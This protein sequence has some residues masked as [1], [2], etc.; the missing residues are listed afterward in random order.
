LAEAR[1]AILDL[2][3][4]PVEESGLDAALEQLVDHFGERNGIRTEWSVEGDPAP[5]L[6]VQANALY[7]IAEEG[8]DNVEYHAGATLVRTC[9]SYAGGVTLRIEDDGQGFA[10]ETVPA[11]RYGLVGIYE[12]AALVDGKVDVSSAPNRGTALTVHIAEPWRGSQDVGARS[13]G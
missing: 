9:L 4:S 6:P 3:S 1:S 2:R 10:P 13:G 12:R 11:D 5:L 7:R 8:L